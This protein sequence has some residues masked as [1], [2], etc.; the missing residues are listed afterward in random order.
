MDGGTDCSSTNIPTYNAGGTIEFAEYEPYEL[1]GTGRDVW[2]RSLLGKVNDIREDI[3]LE[4]IIEDFEDYS[5]DSFAKIIEVTK[6]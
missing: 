3:G 4:P 2:V 1:N 5:D 6:Q